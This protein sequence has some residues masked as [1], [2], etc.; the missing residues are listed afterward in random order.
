MNYEYPFDSDWNIDEIVTVISFYNCVEKAY[1][2][3]ITKDEL[4]DGYK[5]FKTVVDS[6][7]MEKQIDKE[8]KEASGYSIYETLKAAQTSSFIKMNEKI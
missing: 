4:M 6:K 8:F 3:G 1:E 7:S 5:A 2:E